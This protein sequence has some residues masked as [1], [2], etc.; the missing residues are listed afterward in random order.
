MTVLLRCRVED[1]MKQ[2]ADQI[3]QKMGTSTEELVRIFLAALVQGRKMPFLPSAETEED[4]M[5]GPVERRREV[6]DFFHE[7]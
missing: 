7:N 3:S 4:E 5:L 1:R 6:A 2:A